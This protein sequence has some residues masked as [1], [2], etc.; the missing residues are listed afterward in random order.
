MELKIRFLDW[1]AGVPSAMLNQ[2][3]ADKLGIQTKDRISLR[4]MGNNPKEVS[5]TLDTIKGI[6]RENE[7]GVSNEL[8]DRL[9][10]RKGQKVDVNL[11]IPPKSLEFAKKKM[12]GKRLKK[13]EIYSIIKDVVSNSLSESEIA[14]FVSGMYKHGM[15]IKETIHLIEA[16]LKT[17]NQL[18][19]RNKF[20]VDKHSIGGVP[21]NRTTPIVVPICVAAGLTMP[22]TS[23]RAITSAAG[24]ADVIETIAS[25][26]FSMKELKKI[27]KKT[28]GC[29]VWGGYLGMVPADSKIIRV[30]KA[31]KIDPMAQLIAS[32][33]AKK[34]AVGSRYILVDIPYGKGAKVDKKHANFLKKKFEALGKHFKVNLKCVLTDG[35]QPI[36]CGVGPVPELKD[37]IAILDPEKQGP[38]DLEEKSLLLS[39]EIIRMTGK[40]GKEESK[41]KAKDILYSGK[42]FEKFKEIIEAQSG[43]INK[44]KEAKL[45]HN[46]LAKKSG[47]IK[48]IENKKI[49]SLA[50]ITGC[51]LDKQ[52][53]LYLHVLKGEKVKKKQKLITIYAN[54]K[55]RLNEAIRY[56]KEE[57]PIKIS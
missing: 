28:G 49:S 27:I 15:N 17:G 19:L 11:A 1:E 37:V 4:T 53:G 5:T 45:N 26:E 41:K 18:K 51:P 56:F 30:E 10:L 34:L 46:I 21:G 20:V 35:T 42:A 31:L 13:K 32:I 6:I 33:M 24:T 3:T 29:M 57:K 43:N 55:T 52:C 36:G 44:I 25:V 2:K 39:S 8:K 12:E 48:N 7:V 50:R 40:A 22:K 47:K 38:K 14:L 16:I 54:S 23:S 9:S